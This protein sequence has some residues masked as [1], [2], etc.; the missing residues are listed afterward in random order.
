MKDP[1]FVQSMTEQEAKAWN[2]FVGVVKGFLGSHKASNYKE[3]VAQMLEAFKTQGTRMSIKMHFLF[4]HLECFPE[5]L[6]AKIS[7]IHPK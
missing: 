2:G 4:N 3:I 6:G 7:F 1:K 5:N